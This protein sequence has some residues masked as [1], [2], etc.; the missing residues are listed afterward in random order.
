MG[1]NGYD[2]D[3]LERDEDKEEAVVFSAYA[4]VHPRAMV[5]KSLNA[6]LTHVTVVTARQGDDSALEAELAD[7]ESLK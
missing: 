6:L 5:I 2:I 7:L 3:G 4:T 1:E